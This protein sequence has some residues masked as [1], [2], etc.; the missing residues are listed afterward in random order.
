M[1][2]F[3]KVAIIG[4]GLMGGSIGLAVKK[5]R[6]AGEVI[7]VFRHAS[8]LRRALK[9]RAVDRGTLSIEEGVKDADLII[10]ATPVYSIPP[11][12]AKVMRYAKKGAMIT[13]AGS[14]KKWLV[15]EVERKLGSSRRVFFVGSHPMAGSEHA[16]VEFARD[17]LLAD[18][19][20]I[21]TRTP[22]TDRRALGAV[23]NFWSALG[24][25][26][27]I[28]DPSAHDRNI[29]FASH[30]PHLV[31]FGVIGA[32][33]EKYFLYSAE[34]F[35]DTTR[36]ASSDPRMWTDI[37]LTNRKDVLRSARMFK[38]YLG[39]IVRVVKNGDSKKLFRLLKSAKMKR[40][41]F[42]YGK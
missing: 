30:L 3:N 25:R 20:C 8:T 7:G 17:N 33:P 12:A 38:G 36:V 23:I 18:A 14:T 39:E 4:V 41:K 29:S 35:K 2:R 34:G 10:I 40:D 31:A 22:K 5:R 9:R 11:L 15:G 28:M 26:V 1:I 13:D 32:V 6:V 16:G 37:F 19:P 42:F 24:A 21:V 27:A